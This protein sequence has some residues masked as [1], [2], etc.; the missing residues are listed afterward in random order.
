AAAVLGGDIGRSGPRRDPEDLH[1]EVGYTDRQADELG[2]ALRCELF[3]TIPVTRK[4]VDQKAPAVDAIDREEGPPDF[5][6]L[7]EIKCRWAVLCPDPQV[8]IKEDVD[9]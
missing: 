6:I 5:R 9:A 4:I 2:R 1:V 8:C 3:R 7:N